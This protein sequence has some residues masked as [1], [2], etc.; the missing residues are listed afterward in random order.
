MLLLT[1][2]KIHAAK[3]L[4]PGLEVQ[5]ECGPYEKIRS[6]YFPCGPNNWLIRALSYNQNKPLGK[7]LEK[8]RSEYFPCGPNNWLIRALSYSQNKPLGKF[9]EVQW[10]VH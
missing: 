2:C 5:T 1:N 9:L 6:K 7:F 3:Y 8:I 10:E 4:E